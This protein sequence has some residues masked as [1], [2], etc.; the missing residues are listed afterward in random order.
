MLDEGVQ[1]L[2]RANSE[3]GL[4]LS[5]TE[6]DYLRQNEWATTAEDILLRRSKLGL[7]VGP[8]PIAI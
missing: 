7:H 2:I 3:L 1:A 5:D 8:E 6:I 4:A